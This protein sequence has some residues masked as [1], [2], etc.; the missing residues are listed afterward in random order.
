MLFAY[1]YTQKR[2]CR[3]TRCSNNKAWSGHALAPATRWPADAWSGAPFAWRVSR[4]R[5]YWNSIRP[6][7]TPDNRCAAT[8]ATAV[9]RNRSSAT[10]V[11]RVTVTV[12]PISSTANKTTGPV[13]RP[14]NCSH[15]I[16]AACSS[17]EFGQ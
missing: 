4:P 15:A 10:S 2:P 13:C 11:D 3:C 9:T 17:G 1:M 6:C 14:T 7:S 5:G 8:A 16:Y 12:Q